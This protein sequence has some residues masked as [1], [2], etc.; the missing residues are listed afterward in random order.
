MISSRFR[1]SNSRFIASAVLAFAGLSGPILSGS[2]ARAEEPAP[3]V[4]RANTG[5]LTTPLAV[6]WRF[7]SS[8]SPSVS[9]A[10]ILSGNTLYF[11][12]A[13]R[14]FAINP[15]NGAQKWAY[16]SS[17]NLKT[18]ITG[19]MTL[20]NGVLYFSAGDGLYA[21]NAEDGKLKWPRYSIPAGVAT[22]P[23]VIGDRVYFGSSDS[24]LYAL[25]TATGDPAE[26]VWSTARSAGIS[27]GGDFIGDIVNV[28]EMLYYVT[29]DQ[30]LHAVSSVTGQQRWGQRLS[31]DMQEATP[32]IA[33]EYIYLPAGDS[34][35]VFRLS[36][37]T[38]RWQKSLGDSAAV[39]PVVDADG[40]VYMVRQDRYIL[41]IENNGH[42][43][44]WKKKAPRPDNEIVTP[45]VIAGDV[46]LVGTARGGVYAYNKADGALKWR[47]LIKPTSAGGTAPPP[48]ANI[49]ATPLVDGNALYIFTDDGTL[50]AFRSDAPDKLAPIITPLTPEVGDEL[51]GTPPFYVAAL[52]SDEGSGLDTS[53]LVLKIDDKPASRKPLTLDAADKP[54]F[55]LD[56]DTGLLQYT[57]E[58]SSSGRN[59]TLREGVHTISISVKDYMGNLATKS[60]TFHVS[61]E[62][63]KISRRFGATPATPTNGGR[64]GTN[65]GGNRPGGRPGFGGGFGG[66]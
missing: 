44:L 17:D 24:K 28:N 49:A 40:T 48:T 32:V 46:L 43:Y 59:A 66:G 35:Q 38:P 26:G 45:P 19:A 18:I 3:A 52:L 5:P 14:I 54:G 21:V 61:E 51:K 13:S 33:N 53:T 31:S 30:V 50:T 64:P 15:V 10:P 22:S 1:S 36:N 25:Q 29:A 11:A 42:S 6:S 2:I 56:E 55:T 34:V 58:E 39:A 23:L 65:P 57:I 12:S 37:G 41:A 27:S 60:W 63:T 16:P 4:K 20:N 8:V 7:T 9:G 47:Y 62:S